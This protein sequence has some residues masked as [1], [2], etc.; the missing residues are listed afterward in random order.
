MK[1]ERAKS[2]KPKPS[3]DKLGFGQHFTDHM[4][5]IDFA[6]GR[7]GEPAIVPYGPIT[8]EP[9]AAV[10]HYGQSI[11]EGMKAYRGQG[12][13]SSL[14]IFRPSANAQ[15]LNASATRLC[16][17]TLDPKIFVDSIKALVKH[18]A[19]WVPS[20][21]GTSLYIRPVMIATEGFLGVR[22][23]NAYSFLVMLSPVGAYFAEGF[24]GVRIWV[25]EENLRAA[26]GG[27]GAAKTAGNY[28]ASLLA[29]E[30]AKKRGY[31]QV[32][33]L[34]QDR[35]SIEE[36]GTMNVFF[37]I[38]DTLV[39]PPLSDSL[40]AGVTRDSVIQLARHLGQKVEERAVPIEELAAAAKKGT[41]R[42][43]FGTGTAA[44]ISPISELGWRNEK[45]VPGDGKPGP[46]ATK[47]LETHAGITAGTQPD[48]FQWM[49]RI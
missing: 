3:A 22:P 32:L 8:L 19:D 16:M 48:P 45:L 30:R 25:E 6:D 35:R 2:L 36:V 33:W 38:G 12:A 9:T 20:A 1:I 34:D 10:L 18:E 42:E 37:L 13:D 17:P 24:A 43:A 15:R 4:L 11:F 40:L 41:L 5:R 39:T 28:A 26:R 49:E 47:L 23:A 21:P 7:W 44:V 29:G 31:A 27:I 14:R 46:L